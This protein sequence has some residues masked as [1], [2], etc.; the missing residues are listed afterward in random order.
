MLRPAMGSP[1]EKVAPFLPK[2][3]FWLIAICRLL[4]GGGGST[5]FHASMVGGL[6]QYRQRKGTAFE[7]KNDEP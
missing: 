4:I 6:A 1:P 3:A 7:G 2:N 5:A